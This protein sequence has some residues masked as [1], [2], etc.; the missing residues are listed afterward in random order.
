MVVQ[1]TGVF[2]VTNSNPDRVNTA[3]LPP[4]TVCRQDSNRR[5][6]TSRLLHYHSTGGCVNEI[7]FP[8]AWSLLNENF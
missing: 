2:F 7:S 6:E 1:L 5:P 8:T 3:P 4:P